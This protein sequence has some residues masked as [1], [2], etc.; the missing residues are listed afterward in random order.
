L[1]LCT[2]CRKREAFYHRLASGEKLC[3]T[4][5]FRSLVRQV[6]RALGLYSM[7]RPK[8]R[9]F[10][11]VRP[12]KP[13]E[14]VAMAEVF[15]G[16]TRSHGTE[17]VAA[18]PPL[19]KGFHVVEEELRRRGFRT[20][21]TELGAEPRS[22]VELVKFSEALVLRKAGG[23]TVANPLL[24]DELLLLALIGASRGD[25]E[26]FSESM[27]VKR[28]GGSAIVRPFY[29]VISP[30]VAALTFSDP[31]LL[32]LDRYVKPLAPMLG[33]EATSKRMLYEIS[34]GST[35]LLYSSS[36]TVELLQSLALGVGYRCRYCLGFT[37]DERGV[38]SYCRRLERALK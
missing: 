16:A 30:D 26:A 13:L 14:S 19:F 3:R 15:R 2:S 33:D 29:Y 8:E 18:I 9:V 31:R 28:G 6:R 11:V 27:P 23:A 12:D 35:E 21:V 36:K 24:R 10:F 1:T 22:F 7:L 34:W 5:L 4:C 20:V 17:V 32:D 25:R 38:C 37:L